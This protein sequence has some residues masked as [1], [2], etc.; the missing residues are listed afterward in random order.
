[1]I[2]PNTFN[3]QISKCNSSQHFNSVEKFVKIRKLKINSCLLFE[4][5]I[6][7]SNLAGSK[8]S[9]ISNIGSCFSIEQIFENRIQSLPILSDLH[10]L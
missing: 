5:L 8:F 1:M 3:K 10:V 9:L 7:S 2:Y 6:K 4:K